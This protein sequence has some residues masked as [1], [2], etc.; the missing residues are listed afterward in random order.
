MIAAAKSAGF[1]IEST[2]HEASWALGGFVGRHRDLV[3]ARARENSK[4]R[5]T[6]LS[7]LP[8]LAARTMLMPSRRELED[9]FVAQAGRAASLSKVKLPSSSTAT[10]SAT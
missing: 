6:A 5:Q 9:Q 7:V 1:E 8:D 2:L 4:R 10:R 3:C